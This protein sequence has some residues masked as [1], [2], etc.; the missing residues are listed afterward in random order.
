MLGYMLKKFS[1][2]CRVSVERVV[3]GTGLAN[4]SKNCLRWLLHCFDIIFALLFLNHQVYEFLALEQPDKIDPTLHKEV[5]TRD[6]R[7]TRNVLT[8]FTSSWHC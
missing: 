3:S 8:I 1:A 6:I 2:S 7:L 4:V 5:R